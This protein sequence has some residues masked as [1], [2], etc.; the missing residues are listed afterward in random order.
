MKKLINWLF[1]KYY[2]TELVELSN[3]MRNPNLTGDP[4]DDHPKMQRVGGILEALQ[5][6]ELLP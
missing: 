1:I 4:L 2:Y 5:K 3:K 6:L